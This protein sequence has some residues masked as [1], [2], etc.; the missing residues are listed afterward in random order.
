MVCNLKSKHLA[1]AAV[2]CLLLMFMARAA[3]PTSSTG[4]E[5]ATEAE[6]GTHFILLIDD[7]GDMRRRHR[8]VL[9]GVLPEFLLT[10]SVEGRATDPALP[11]F[12]PGRDRIS[13]VY[14]TILKTTG[15]GCREGQRGMSV[16]PDEIF[17][18]EGG[19]G[20]DSR[21]ELDAFLGDSLKKPCRNRGADGRG[22]GQYSPIATSQMLV[23]PYLQRQLKDDRLYSRTIL[24]VANNKRFNTAEASPAYELSKF[25]TDTDITD[26]EDARQVSH[27]ASRLFSFNTFPG[28]DIRVRPDLF[29][30][31]SEVTPRPEPDLMVSLPRSIT[32]DRVAVSR[33][34]LRVV[35]EARGAGDMRILTGGEGAAY[36]FLPLFME[37]RFRGAGG[38]AWRVGQR[39]LEGMAP[40]DLR[41]C[42]PPGC[43]ADGD[44]Y[45]VSLF[46]SAGGDLMLSS[47]DSLPDAGALD[48]NVWMRYQTRLYDH[49]LV[50]SSERHVEI[51]PTRADTLPG[52]LFLPDVTLD[53]RELARQYAHDDDGVTTQTEARSRILLRHSLYTLCL[54]FVTVAAVALAVAYL[55]RTRYHR[56]F[57]PKLKWEPAS[58]VVVDFNRPAASRLLV[59]ALRVVNEGGLPWLGRMLKNEEQPT[60]RA[61]LQLSYNFFKGSG[62]ELVEERPLGFVR[63]GAGENGRYYLS[64]D[65]EEAVSDGT[66]V[67]IFL[68]ADAIRDYPA[69]APAAQSKD[70]EIDL[71]VQIGWR[72]REHNGGNSLA[73]R[74]KPLLVADDQ[75]EL[76][77]PIQCSLTVRPEDKR[78]PRV[79]FEPRGGPLEFRKGEDVLVGKFVFHSRAGHAFARPF[80]G[81]TYTV[82]VLKENVPLGGQPMRLERPDVEVAPGRRVEVPVYLFCDGEAVV[83]PDPVS[84]TYTFTLVGDFDADSEPGSHSVTLFRDPGRPEIY[85][86]LLFPKPEREIFWSKTGEVKQRL[87]LPDGSAAAESPVE[88][89]TVVLDA[90]PVRFRS[91]SPGTPNLL[92]LRVGNSAAVGRGQ[93]AVGVRT[94][95]WCPEVE[96]DIVMAAGRSHEDLLGVYA[97]GESRLL[98]EVRVGAGGDPQV[99]DVR[100]HHALIEKIKSA[101]IPADKFQARV[102]LDITVTDDE[103]R[104]VKRPALNFVIP[105]RLE[106]LPGH[107]WL[108]IDFG[109]SAIAAALGTAGGVR[110]IPLQDLKPQGGLS[111]AEADPFN[112]ERGD[113]Y[114]LPSLVICDADRR[115]KTEL[116]SRPGFPGY[117]SPELSLTPGEPDFVG[118]PAT[119]TQIRLRPERIVYSLKSWLAKAPGSIPM[120][121]G[122]TYRENGRLVPRESLPLEKMVESGFAAL[123]EGYLL[124]TPEY[125]ADRIVLCHPN[126][127]T[128]RHVKLL[129]DIAHSALGKAKPHGF[130]IPLQERIRLISESDA[131]AYYYCMEQMSNRP[132]GGSELI[133]VYDFGAG[134]LDLSLIRVTWEKEQFATPAGWDVL[135]RIGVPVAGNYLDELLA[136]TVDDL[137][138]DPLLPGREYV[139]YQY[140]IVRKER[141]NPQAG[142]DYREA[143]LKLWHA[144]RDAKHAWDGASPLKI[145]VGVIGNNEN[146]LRLKTGSEYPSAAGLP[147]A[148]RRG[149]TAYSK[150]HLM[151][152]PASPGS[153]AGLSLNEQNIFLSI[154]AERVHED[155]RV[156]AFVE[157]VTETV[158]DELCGGADVPAGEVEAVVVSGRGALWPGLRDRVLKRF[159]PDAARPNLISDGAM[160]NA[161]VRGAIGRQV[162]VRLNRNGDESRWKP[163]LGVLL[164][165]DRDLFVEDDWEKQ[166]INLSRS[167]TF[168]IVQVNLKSPNPREDLKPVSLRRHF[169]VDLVN[170]KFERDELWDETR[171]LYIHKAQDEKNGE[172]TLYIEDRQ[173]NHQEPIITQASAGETVTDLPWPIGPAYILEPDGVRA[174]RPEGP[175][176]EEG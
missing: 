74:L 56:P 125:H 152:L 169:Y 32:V 165:D 176:G 145:K 162:N 28:W 113:P 130:G 75:G 174:G 76:N 126:T 37:M 107:N 22:P 82:Q 134:T 39:A 51:V 155:S 42:R 21:G 12:R 9:A 175:S 140:P 81:C 95:A 122:I 111:L 44:T 159:H 49:M 88:S 78:K 136:R 129:R 148:D 41:D 86:S 97:H 128:Q 132:R 53:N 26:I 142:P 116:T 70:F 109:T 163:K 144:I 102:T 33:D 143:I 59:G 98:P 93:V 133:L 173:G 52:Y 135:G 2:V 103:G 157:F 119:E 87:V 3:G 23:L 8:D 57:K 38:A 83:N 121:S 100:I 150:E 73:S 54:I 63:A 68:A 112:S 79:T 43:I 90:H 154:P 146:I 77:E 141:H 5:A 58:E 36:R 171:E 94:A 61:R 105:I 115:E 16:S 168:R 123:A 6:P 158:I 18:F 60:R 161:V 72:A 172:L 19:E 62:L 27:Q 91:G 85:L 117:Y 71:S 1:F 127:F 147:E 153:Q 65:A 170:R 47:S 137:L 14:F 110:P 15:G 164:N 89:S 67:Y 156:S 24:I 17:T 139:T 118:L 4:V 29:L 31:V 138:K 166:P 151:L 104:A 106:Q 114:L 149:S 101:V 40:V 13:L 20:V 45:T 66:H 34:K 124:V 7:S 120:K 10:G 69:S 35:P 108:C 46:D 11:N 160:K 55:F 96:T 99:L 80:N 92:T 48:V 64:L 30:V 84:D 131:V 25:D 167:E 50:K